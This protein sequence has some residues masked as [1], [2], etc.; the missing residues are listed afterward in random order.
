[1]AIRDIALAAAIAASNPSE[2]GP[3]KPENPTPVDT[4]TVLV[5]EAVK[6]AMT[7]DLTAMKLEGLLDEVKMKDPIISMLSQEPILLAWAEWVSGVV[8]FSK[9]EALWTYK[10][11]SQEEKEKVRKMYDMLVKDAWDNPEK[12]KW[13]KSVIARFIWL[14]RSLGFKPG[15]TIWKSEEQL[16]S[17]IEALNKSWFSKE[18][19]TWLESS[20]GKAQE[21]DKYIMELASLSPEELQARIDK[22]KK[23]IEKLKQKE[24]DI[25]RK[26]QDVVRKEQRL[27]E[28]EQI[29]KNLQDV[30]DAMKKKVG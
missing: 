21:R 29:L 2:Q 17:V 13:V 11:F 20:R 3:K 6:H 16:N 7:T 26:E 1:M 14:L 9:V 22:M 5:Q 23:E 8:D 15:N 10:E 25:A 30:H 18:F 27:R 24:Q 28:L 4:R 19:V 12:Q